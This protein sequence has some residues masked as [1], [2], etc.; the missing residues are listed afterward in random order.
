VC[1]SDLFANRIAEITL[2]GISQTA[3]RAKKHV[4]GNIGC[5]PRLL[6]DV[7]QIFGFAIARSGSSAGFQPATIAASQRLSK[8]VWE[9]AI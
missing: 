6:A 1:S 7:P 3:P 2:T 9:S 8:G 4:G 5:R